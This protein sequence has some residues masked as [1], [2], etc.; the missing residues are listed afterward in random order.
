MKITKWLFQICIIVGVSLFKPANIKAQSDTSI[1]KG[2]SAKLQTL[3]V[4]AALA[5][6]G[7]TK[8]LH[9]A[10]NRGLDAG[11]TINELKET[12]VHVYAYAGFPR[13]LNTLSTLQK[14]IDKR[15]G[16]GITDSIGRE[17]SPIP[18][19]Q[20]RYELGS[21]LQTRLLGR[22]MK[23]ATADFSPIID[24]FLKAH[25]F[26]DIFARDILDFKTRELITISTL[27]GL[28]NAD[29]Q[30]RSHIGVS[31]YNGITEAE[32]NNWVAIIH[33]RVG[34]KEGSTA[35]K[36]VAGGYWQ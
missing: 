23:T 17:S 21:G 5:G 16:K 19:I 34:V 27:V 11:W 10:M 35:K 32:L 12:A 28:G 9:T 18:V 33:S 29:A 24:T 1:R 26:G 20:S 7:D 15:K 4:I 6:K 3:T 31:I 22:E 36:N 13:S 25:L 14:V 30:L 2:L 8:L